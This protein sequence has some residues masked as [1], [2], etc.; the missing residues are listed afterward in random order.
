MILVLGIPDSGK[1]GIAEDIVTKMALEDKKLY[2]ATMIPFGEEGKKRVERHRAQRSGK[3]FY[4]IEEPLYVAEKVRAYEC[5]EKCSCLLEC[6]SNM[7]GNALS[8]EEFKSAVDHVCR[9]IAELDCC[10]RNL[11]VVSNSFKKDDQGYDEATRNYV[12]ATDLV[13]ERLMEMA[14]TTYQYLEGEW[15]KFENS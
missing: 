2:V 14:S 11:V 3:G 12:R 5:H 15:R 1:S 13:N 4:T 6:V 7:V 10:V 8:K 9:E